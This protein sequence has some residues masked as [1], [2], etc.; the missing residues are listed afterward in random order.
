ML[1]NILLILIYV[2]A[3]A[4]VLWLCRKVAWLGKVGPVLVL[5]LLGI[6]LGNVWHPSGMAAIQE[7]LSSA[8]VPFA[9]PLMLFGCTF[10]MGET[11]SQ[12]LAI[13][14]GLVSVIVVVIV[15]YLIFG[16][17][18]PDGA[19]IGGMLTGV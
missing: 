2:L 16:H 9:I 11:R 7:A 4:G 5:Y 10:R 6:I 1:E 17:S 13:I 18:I 8:A 3:P 15:G 19:K 14:S 12:V